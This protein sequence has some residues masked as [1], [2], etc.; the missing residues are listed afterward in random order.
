MNNVNEYRGTKLVY[1]KYMLSEMTQDITYFTLCEE[2]LQCC[3]YHFNRIKIELIFIQMWI[4]DNWR[5]IYD[6]GN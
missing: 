5:T 2:L 3:K 1:D 6:L 4:I